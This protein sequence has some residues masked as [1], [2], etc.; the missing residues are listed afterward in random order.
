MT[1]SITSAYIGL[2]WI[3]EGSGLFLFLEETVPPRGERTCH[4]Y[5]QGS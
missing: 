4:L 5:T 3:L 1:K 2:P